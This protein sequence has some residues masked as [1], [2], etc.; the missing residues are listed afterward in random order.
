ME[1]MFPVEVALGVDGLRLRVDKR[2]F[3]RVMANL[4]DNATDY[5][6][7]VT[8]VVVDREPPGAGPARSIRVIVEDHGPGVQPADRAHLFERF[9]RGTRSGQRASGEGTGLGLSLVTEH[10]RLHGGSVRI[11]DAEGGGAR[12]IVELPLTEPDTDGTEVLL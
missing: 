2:R 9:Y 7:G 11:E 1:P 12:F 8:R 6:G 4:V 10:V 5:A 3:E